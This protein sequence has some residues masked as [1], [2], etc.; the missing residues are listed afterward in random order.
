MNRIS[1]PDPTREWCLFRRS[2][3]SVFFCFILSSSYIMKPYE[4]NF[5][6]GAFNLI[7]EGL[8]YWIFL[9]NIQSC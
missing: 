7:Y 8:S 5:I 2:L 1:L 3:M 9:K 4:V 6:I